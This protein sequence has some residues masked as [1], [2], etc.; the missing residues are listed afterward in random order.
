MKTYVVKKENNF[1]FG[2]YKT[3][4]C[5]HVNKYWCAKLKK[6]DIRVAERSVQYAHSA[7]PKL[8]LFDI[9]N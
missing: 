7:V 3:K 4:C 2:E 5:M 6:F 9:S 1:F 8:M